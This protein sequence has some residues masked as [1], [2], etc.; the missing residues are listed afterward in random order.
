M[1]EYK[2]SDN[3]NFQQVRRQSFEGR[4][5][6]CGKDLCRTLGFNGGI[7]PI[8]RYCKDSVKLLYP[9]KDPISVMWFIPE[10][11]IYSLIFQSKR[12]EAES[13]VRWIAED[14]LPS[15]RKTGEF[16]LEDVKGKNGKTAV[17]LLN[18]IDKLMEEHN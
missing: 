6:L 7:Y 5:V 11:D 4:A 3:I 1:E 16:S 2:W 9:E 14:V 12:D 13:F 17:R 18:E 10:E 8:C 15:I